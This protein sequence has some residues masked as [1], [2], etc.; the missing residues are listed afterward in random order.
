MS[1]INVPDWFPLYVYHFSLDENV[2]LMTNEQVG[3]YVR[4]L[5]HEWIHGSIPAEIPALAGLA[6]TSVEHMEAIWEGVALCFTSR[7]GRLIN[8]RLE[9]ERVKANRRLAGTR[10]GG[11]ESAR[12]RLGVSG[13][14][15]A[16]VPVQLET[17][18]SWDREKAFGQLWDA[19][20]S[21]GRVR[22]PLSEQYFF[23]K[24]LTVED[25]AALLTAVRPG[26]KWAESEKWGNGFV[27]NLPEFLNQECWREEPEPAGGSAGG[28][29]Y[30]KWEPPK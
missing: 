12:R 25:S 3:V 19:Y 23:Q 10:K 30:T 13:G 24:V 26:G 7:N 18:D 28:T 4:L 14:S 11:K 21:K 29:V 9:D 22:R 2:A 20:P 1:Q 17:D 16:P 5:C 6:R 27:M 15:A 8:K